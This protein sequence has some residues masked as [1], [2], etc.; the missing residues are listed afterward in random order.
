M[1]SP[2]STTKNQ[3]STYKAYLVRIW[4]EDTDAPAR[5]SAQAVGDGDIVRFA[6]IEA[7][8]EYLAAQALLMQGIARDVA[9]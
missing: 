7:L 1:T 6:T 8:F 9:E 5:A 4:L 2:P 3:I